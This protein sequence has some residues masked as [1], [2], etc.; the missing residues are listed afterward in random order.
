[1]K[2]I[3]IVEDNITVREGLTSIIKEINSEIVVESTGYATQALQ[4]ARTNRVD[5]F[6]LDIQLMDYSGIELAK[7]IRELDGYVMTPIVFITSIHSK[8]LYA[9]KEIH[10]Y[11]YIIKPFRVDTVKKTLTAVIDY[12]IV[13][14]KEREVIIFKQK[15]FSISVFIDEILYVE[16]VNRKLL[17][18]TT[19][20]EILLSTYT[21]VKV[22]DMLPNTFIRVHKGIVINK[23]CVSVVDKKEKNIMLT[24]DRIVPYGMK[25]KEVLGEWL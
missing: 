18:V 10:C 3:M 4:H 17:V 8:E 24:D 16:Y 7:E 1:M 13:K 22:M 6:I 9:F 5:F 12:G 14:P 2:K 23:S 15:R 21:L 11:D 20:E 25:Y 19:H